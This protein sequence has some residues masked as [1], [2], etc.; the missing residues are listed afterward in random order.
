MAGRYLCTFS[1]EPY[2]ESLYYALNNAP[3]LGIPQENILV[4]DDKWYMQQEF[5]RVNSWLF[6][7]PHKRGCGWYAFKPYVIIQAMSHLNDGDVLMWLDAD[8]VPMQDVSVLYD[9]ALKEDAVFFEVSP[10]KVQSKWCKRDCFI[11]MG[12]DTP[13]YH[14]SQP[15][16][17]RFMLFRKGSYKVEQFL[18][19]W[20]IFCTH[21][22]A[23]TFDK[24]VLGDELPG[25][26]EHRCEQA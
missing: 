21:K 12:L 24:S 3:L 13:E 4:Y 16:V 11:V 7:H 17:A 18:N 10:E 23:N 8:T 15:G 20:L 26:V 2:D 5:V 25:H 14:N 9:L 1:G 19:E 22:L 6:D